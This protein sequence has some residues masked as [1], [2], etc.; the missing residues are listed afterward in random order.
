VM[1]EQQLINGLMLGGIYVLVAVA[2]TLTIGI[3]NFLN[4]SIPGVF[5]LAGVFTWALL[6]AGVHWSL[7][8]AGALVVGAAASLLVERCTYSWM[9]SSDHYVPLVSSM[10]F[11]IL[12]ENLV[13]VQWGSDLQRVVLPFSDLNI[14]YASL[15]VSIPQLLSLTLAVCLVVALRALLLKTQMGRAL[16]AVAESATTAE[17]LGIGVTR[18]VPAVFIIGGLFAALAGMLFA[19]NYQQVHPYMGEEVALK[20]IS[21]MVIGGMGNVWGAVLGGLLI[22]LAEVLSIHFLNADFVDFFVYGLLLVILFFKPT[23]L[24]GASKSVQ[25]KF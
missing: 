9:R 24:L 10:G 3:L 21:A 14:R 7:A 20:G 2:F 22:G 18:L 19:L 6:K 17:I 5:M 16:R 11:L 1:L 25:E 13:L 15:V 23:G 8:V 12:F 4:F